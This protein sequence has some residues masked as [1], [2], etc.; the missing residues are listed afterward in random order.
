MNDEH[1][2]KRRT[3]PAWVPSTAR[4]P[5]TM[6]VGHRDGSVTCGDCGKLLTPPTGQAN[7]IIRAAR[8]G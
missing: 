2:T 7:P 3:A 4:C 8:H 5:H 1:E 6:R